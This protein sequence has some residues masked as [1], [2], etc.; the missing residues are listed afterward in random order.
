MIARSKSLHNRGM[1][2]DLKWSQSPPPP[3]LSLLTKK[4][5]KLRERKKEKKN[6]RKKEK[7][8]EREKER[9]RERGKT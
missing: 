7:K 8:R 3:S 1:K 6:E 4:L 9:K 2:Y 5:N